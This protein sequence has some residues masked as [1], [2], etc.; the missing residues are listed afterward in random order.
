MQETIFFS[1]IYYLY[2][3]FLLVIINI[4]YLEYCMVVFK[5]NRLII[6]VL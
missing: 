4:Q 1:Y 5:V 6:S 2:V 3:L